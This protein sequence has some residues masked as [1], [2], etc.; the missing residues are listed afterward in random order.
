MKRLAIHS[1]RRAE[2][3]R[4]AGPESGMTLIEVLVA[5]TLLGLL[6]VGLVMAFQ[7]GASSWQTTRERLTLDRR[8]ATANQILQS[9]LAG[10]IPF[11]GEALD[12]GSRRQRFLF[13]QGETLSM[14][15]VSSYSVT[16]G[17]RGGL[18]VFELQIVGSP[19]GRRILLNQV[20]LESPIGLSRFVDGFYR[21]PSSPGLRPRFRPIVPY[22]TS[23][24]IVDELETCEFRYLEKPPGIEP[25]TRWVPMWQ[26][27]RKL[28][29][30][31]AINVVPRLDGVRLLPV[32]IAVP[33]LS[34][35]RDPQA[36]RTGARAGGGVPLQGAPRQ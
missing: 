19:R 12:A 21:D 1:H 3:S 22:A 35:G 29:E 16:E 32:S 8:I 34:K 27:L 4:A 15:F 31:V 6:S 13:F 25:P 14:R 26:E 18:N 2:P 11:D 24:V 10:V 7:V 5:V 20:P 28:P 30:A 17:P 9:S 23:L 33:I 36:G